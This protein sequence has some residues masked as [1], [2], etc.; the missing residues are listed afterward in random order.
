MSWVAVREPWMH[1]AV[2]ATTSSLD[3]KIPVASIFFR[4]LGVWRAAEQGRG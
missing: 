1:S 4:K 3:L 2:S